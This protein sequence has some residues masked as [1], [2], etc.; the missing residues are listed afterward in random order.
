M[1]IQNTAHNTSNYS[2]ITNITGLFLLI[3][4][5]LKS[6]RPLGR[7]SIL[8]MAE[9][10]LPHVKENF[11]LL[12]KTLVNEKLIEGNAERFSLTSSGLTTL[13]KIAKEHS[14]HTAFYNEYYQ[15]ILNSRVHHIF[16]EK[17]YGKDLGQHGMADLEQL[18]FMIKELEIGSGMSLLDFGCGDG[19]ITEYLA[20][21]TQARATGTDISDQAI[22]IA[23]RRAGNKGEQIKFLLADLDGKLEQFEDQSFDRVVAIDSI[24]FAQNQRLIVARLLDLLK[25]GGKMGVFYIC[26]PAID[27]NQTPFIKAI[28]DSGI[29]YTIHDLS[30]Q[31]CEHWRKK[32]ETLLELEAMFKEEGNEFLFKNRLAECDGLDAFHRYLYIVTKP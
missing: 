7:N 9:I 24:F 22:R 23:N 28:I 32:K 2:Q 11:D 27:G 1:G 10:K 12:I 4:R 31:N 30:T 29:N 21:I 15:A 14:L 3:D 6:D 19:Q 25:H 16:C 20:G 18:E 5:L 13:E 8:P 26:P 17:V